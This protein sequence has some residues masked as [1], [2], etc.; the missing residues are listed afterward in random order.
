M[1]IERQDYPNLAKVLEY[2][3][4]TEGNIESLL[5]FAIDHKDTE[6]TILLLHYKQKQI[7]FS[8]TEEAFSL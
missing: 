2:P 3:V 1:L 8:D 5:Q 7:G 6:A 4:I